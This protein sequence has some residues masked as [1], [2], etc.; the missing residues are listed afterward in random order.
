MKLEKYTYPYGYLGESRGYVVDDAILP[1]VTSILQKTKSTQDKKAL[2][3]WKSRTSKFEQQSNMD[4]GTAVHSEI[5][6]YLENGDF[7]NPDEMEML[8]TKKGLTHP[9]AYLKGLQPFLEAQ[10]PRPILVEGCVWHPLGYA[11]RIDAVVQLRNDDFSPSSWN[12]QNVLVDWKTTDSFK[13]SK[14]VSDYKIQLSAYCGALNYVYPDLKINKA[15]LVFCIK[16]EVAQVIRVEP[17]TI[18]KNWVVWKTRLNDFKQ[19]IDNG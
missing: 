17:E 16:N 10:K 4:R 6:Y 8:P 19:M 13:S 12:T 5:E 18:M 9:M 1:G 15:M 7:R 14:A 2:E 3:N 11:G